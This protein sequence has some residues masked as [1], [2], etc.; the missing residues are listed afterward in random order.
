V[1]ERMLE[2]AQVEAW[3]EVLEPSCGKGDLLDAL[4]ELHPELSVHA[5]EWNR[6]LADILA[7]KGYEVQFSDFLT[8]DRVY[9]RI[10]LNPPF[11]DGLDIE[12]VRH[13]YSLLNDGGRLVSV[14]SEGPFFRAD[15]KSAAFRDWLVEVSAQVERL[16][17]DAFRGRNAFRETSVRTRLVV[18][19][20][21]AQ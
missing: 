10:L 12:H 2:L 1:I 18:I 20:K 15:K 3:H 5:I 19:D 6:T 7:A 14:M 13:A 21:P 16:P 11:E 17:D 9:D 8:H 4:K